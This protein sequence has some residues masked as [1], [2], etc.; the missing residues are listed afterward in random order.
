MRKTASAASLP[1][2]SWPSPHEVHLQGRSFHKRTPSCKNLSGCGANGAEGG[3]LLLMAD[4]GAPLNAGGASPGG[5][6]GG[7]GLPLY[8]YGGSRRYS[9]DKRLKKKKTF[10]SHRWNQIT[11][12]SWVLIR[13]AVFVSGCIFLVHAASCGMFF[14]Y[15]IPITNF[16]PQQFFSSMDYVPVVPSPLSNIQSSYS[17]PYYHNRAAMGARPA[18]VGV[19][20]GPAFLAGSH[21]STPKPPMPK[22]VHQTYRD[23]E[24]IPKSL[25]KSMESWKKKNRG[26]EFRFYSDQDVIEFVQKEFPEYLDAF[27][28]LTKIV[29]RADF[30]RYLVLLKHGG[31]Y[32]DLDTECTRPLDGFIQPEDDVIV[33]MESMSPSSEYAFKHHFVRSIQMLQ[34]I[35]IS[36]PN[37]PILRAV[38]DHINDNADTVFSNNTNI[39]TLMR[40][41]P[42]PWTDAVL[43]YIDR[44]KELTQ[45]GA[46]GMSDYEFMQHR[47]RVLPRVVFGL[48]EN[49]RDDAKLLNDKRVAVVH[50]FSGSWKSMWGWSKTPAIL[51]FF[52]NLGGLIVSPIRQVMAPAAG[53]AEA[54]ATAAT[55]SSHKTPTP[56]TAFMKDDDRDINTVLLHDVTHDGYVVSADAVTPFDIFVDRPGRDTIDIG[57]G[58]RRHSDASSV[59]SNCGSFEAGMEADQACPKGLNLMS[60][61]IAA[62]DEF[63]VA[64]SRR[65]GV[66]TMLKG[67]GT[68]YSSAVHESEEF[69]ATVEVEAGEG[70]DGLLPGVESGS[71]SAAPDA[72]VEG[73]FVDVGAGLGYYSLGV[74]ARGNRVIAF[75]PPGRHHTLFKQSIEFNRLGDFV[76]VN[77]SVLGRPVSSACSDDSMGSGKA[78]R[79]ASISPV[80][81]T[82]GTGNST[83]TT[84]G[85]GAPPPCERRDLDHVVI[86]DGS[87]LGSLASAK[88]SDGGAVGATEGDDEVAASMG[89]GHRRYRIVAMRIAAFEQLV[90]ILDGA[91]SVFSNKNV[92]IVLPERSGG[93]GGRSQVV[94]SQGPPL[95]VSIEI[96]PSLLR[97][98]GTDAK[99]LL[100][101]MYDLHYTEI[102]H[103]GHVCSAR[104][105]SIRFRQAFSNYKFTP[106]KYDQETGYFTSKDRAEMDADQS[107]SSVD[108][109]GD[110]WCKLGPDAFHLIDRWG[111]STRPE[112]VLLRYTGEDSKIDD[113]SWH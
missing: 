17:S 86:R 39:D 109:E 79:S 46:L 102:A 93:K 74:A 19:G 97:E 63:T 100:W 45:S 54:N 35:I 71:G 51:K 110:P 52:S 113:G 62:M 83:L 70:R 103:K 80:K 37:H 9:G 112:V 65:W 3:S 7:G 92:D 75:E 34:W 104:W 18:G 61:F 25:L 41:G 78:A 105:K 96:I 31:V 99:T 82:K 30:F 98:E 21:E 48:N 84:R 10:V 87:V 73:L 67:D 15:R 59:L 57:D 26:W 101:K 16:I 2:A 50:H 68:G 12:L 28:R 4:N 91:K 58:R 22:I 111:H 47:V 13:A 6:G 81:S 95:Y 56:S 66:G 94:Q 53:L 24:S 44:R 43:Q 88:G 40:T 106:L 5:G 107:G 69:A 32:A 49:H 27:N 85:G 23:V 1:V 76:E 55:S 8:G 11:W 14:C 38:C 20:V 72:D 90:A 60:I 77:D 42:G 36:R 33:G 29:E 89:A 108:D 64:H